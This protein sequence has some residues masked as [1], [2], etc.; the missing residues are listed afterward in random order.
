MINWKQFGKSFEFA[1]S[2]LKYVF[3]NEQNFQVQIIFGL[4]IIGIM[5]ILKVSAIEAA[6]LTMIIA[7]VLILE[8]LNTLAEKLLDLLKPRMNSYVGIIKDIMAAAVLV[9]SL[10]SVIIGI[11]ILGPKLLDIFE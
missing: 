10:S 6:I 5:P 3:Q 7:S 11:L 2:G 1:W 4:L 9:A 8:I